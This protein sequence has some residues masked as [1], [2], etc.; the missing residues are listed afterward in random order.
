MKIVRLADT[1]VHERDEY[2]VL[3]VEEILTVSYYFYF[4]ASM[5]PRIPSHCS[6]LY[7]QQIARG[8]VC[9]AWC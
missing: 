9:A 6:M 3:L 4:A 2:R 7:R 5:I 1:S 8:Q